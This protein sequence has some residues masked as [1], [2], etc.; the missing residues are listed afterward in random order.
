[1]PPVPSDECGLDPTADDLE[2]GA[3]ELCADPP[4]PPDP[5][6][7]PTARGDLVVVPIEHASVV[8]LWDGRA[9]YAD[10]VGGAGPYRD[11]PPA[12]VVVITHTHGDHMDANTLR[13][14]VTERT[15]LVIPSAVAGSLASSGV[16]DTAQETI[17]ANGETVEIG[18][19][20]TVEAVAMYNLTPDRLRYHAKGQGNSYVIDLA[21]TRVY[22]S[23]DTEDIPEMRALENISLAFICMNLQFT[24]TPDQAASAVLD[25]RPRVVYPYHYRGQSTERFRSLVE[26]ESSEIEVRL[27][28]WYP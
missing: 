2:C 1:V 8:L 21:G 13:A 15:S 16:L 10:P 25:F 9:I 20:I 4:D 23:G 26:E 24:M 18:S 17:L 5:D 12:D 3:F 14:V 7:V 6:A 11:L 28:N 27:R 19:D 22:V